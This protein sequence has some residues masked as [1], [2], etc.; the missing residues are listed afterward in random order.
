M[1]TTAGLSVFA[2]IGVCYLLV[3]VAEDVGA[4]M[5]EYKRL[6]CTRCGGLMGSF[7]PRDP[8]D[9]SLHYYCGLKKEVENV[10]SRSNTPQRLV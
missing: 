7:T 9:E 1:Y 6:G 4:F 10:A 3:Q 8:K 5:R 2:F